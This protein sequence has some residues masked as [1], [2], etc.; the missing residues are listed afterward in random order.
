MIPTR[1]EKYLLI[2]IDTYAGNVQRQLV[3]YVFGVVDEAQRGNRAEP[4]PFE[5]G[6]EWEGIDWS[7]TDEELDA[8]PELSDYINFCSEAVVFQDYDNF[9]WPFQIE[10]TDRDN[11]DNWTVAVQIDPRYYPYLVS[12]YIHPLR[13]R[14]AQAAERMGFNILAVRVRTVTLT[15]EEKDL[16]TPARMP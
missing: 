15:T 2:D 16:I 6:Y 13:I 1:E 7:P 3:S 9:S 11:S 8:D 5:G 12:E 4:S 14:L 10:R